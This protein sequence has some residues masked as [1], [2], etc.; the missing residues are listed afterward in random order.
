M[1]DANQKVN[2]LNEIPTPVMVVDREFNVKFM[3]PAGAKAVSKS[4]EHCIG[5]KCF[6]LFNTGHCN[7]PNCQVKKAMEQDNLFTSDTIAKLPTGELPIRY[8]GAPLKDKNGKVIGG[9][10]YVLDISK[11]LEVTKG[12]LALAEAA[13]RGKLDTRADVDRFEGNYRSIVQG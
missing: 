13:V 3:N 11:E 7:T 12:V 9:L 4:T 2:F 1:D 8:T 10:E 6:N 5:Q